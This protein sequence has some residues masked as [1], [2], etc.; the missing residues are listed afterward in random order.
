[1]SATALAS[2]ETLPSRPDAERSLLG[3][4]LIDGGLLTRVME[5]LVPEDFAAESHR[6]VY[7]ACL[8]LSDRRD[9]VDLITV[10]SELERNG[11]LDRAGGAAYLSSLVDLVP[12]VDNIESY[13][14]LV[15]EAA[16]RRRLILQAR[17]S[18]RDAIS[19]PDAET[20]LENAQRELVEIAKG[21]IKGGFVKLSQ[22][23]ERN[24]EEI[25]KIHGRG[26][27][28]TGLPTGFAR[29]NALTQ[30]F[31]K[32]DLIVIAARPGMGKSALP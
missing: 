7:E 8:N 9:G 6:L 19:G 20:A 28:L 30:G 15:Q 3:S 5:F 22:I 16:I 13:A 25:Q 12:D 29:L 1:M 10:Q 21:S 24:E 32:T 18:I 23:A 4:V 31:Q 26:T 11:R 14:R 17:R 2:E 27:M